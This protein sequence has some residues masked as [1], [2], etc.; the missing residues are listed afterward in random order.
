[1]NYQFRLNDYSKKK[2]LIWNE[3]LY[4]DVE[5]APWN[6]NFRGSDDT[7]YLDIQT[8]G[9]TSF[10][11][12]VPKHIMTE[13][14]IRLC[15][16]LAYTR[17]VNMDDTTFLAIYYYNEVRALTKKILLHVLDIIAGGL[18]KKTFL[19]GFNNESFDDII[20][21]AR[22]K[23][24]I[25]CWH[26][27]LS[28]G[29]E[30]KLYTA[31]LYYWCK[32]YGFSKLADV[33]EYMKI[34]KIKQWNSLEEFLD[35]NIR[36]VMILPAFVK[37]LN[38]HG[39]YALR[40]ATAARRLQS[41]EM[42]EKL[43]WQ[44]IFSD[45]Q[46]SDSI[47]LFG[48]RTEP[49]YAIGENL[50]Y[51]D[52]NSLYPYTMVNF[53]FPKPTVWKS[54]KKNGKEITDGQI[55]HVKTSCNASRREEI[56]EFLDECGQYILYLA[57]TF[58]CITP[59]M[60]K[61]VFEDKSPWFGV[62]FV[63]LHGIRPEWKEYEKQLLHYFPFP[64][65]KDG[66]TLF[67]FDPDDIY[68]VQFYELLWLC[69]FDYEIVGHIEYPYY[70]RFPLAEEVYGRY[71]RRKELKAKKDSEEK[72]LKLLLN[73]GYG[74][75]ATRQRTK[76]AVTEQ[77]EY[78]RYFGYW[79]IAADKTEFDVYENDNYKRIRVRMTARGPVFSVEIADDTQRY[80]KNTVPIW[81]VAITSNARFSLYSYMLN[82]I[83]VP[84]EV[85]ER[86][87][88]YYVDTDSMFCTE[89]LYQA[90]AHG[91]AIGDELGQLKLEEAAVNCF[92]LAPKTYIIVKDGKIMKKFKGT[93]TM[94][95]RQIISQSVK[96]GFSAFLRVALRPEQPQKRRL[97]EDYS[98]T[99]TPSPEPGTETLKNY[100]ETLKKYA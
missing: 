77:N 21:G 28:D 33:G 22:L 96:S 55:I 91:G 23:E 67:S 87:R 37:M 2:E 75:F 82:G 13:K 62:L 95:Q 9:I 35:Y 53:L 27:H 89:P 11:V 79:Q 5:T 31:D 26:Y 94:F 100:Y 29:K 51:L 34:P 6:E 85:T 1:M 42:H 93:G 18:K 98:F 30:T 68:C 24:D 78:E 54:Y 7:K 86:Y 73:A 12:M 58:K 47:P 83:L 61:E 99:A 63:K 59:Q 45:Q 40:P 90:L 15:K 10:C 43:G 64:R 16:N 49:Y 36:D 52:V 56:Q 57:E 44:R 66:Y 3:C 74:I 92:F 32:S 84:P 97:E 60:L 19:C 50:Y 4:Y 25:S 20:I 69:F 46:I 81:A 39:L 8:V 80:A 38:Q 48:G 71:Q 70:D 88:I 72:A 14:R 65:K 76:R 41:Q 17:E